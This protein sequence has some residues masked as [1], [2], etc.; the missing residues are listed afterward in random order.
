[1]LFSSSTFWEASFL[2]PSFFLFFP[3]VS[4]LTAVFVY[5]VSTST[6]VWTLR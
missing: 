6:T 2:F 1:V 5:F 3:N 4:T